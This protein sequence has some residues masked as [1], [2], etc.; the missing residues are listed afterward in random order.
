VERRILLWEYLGSDV[1]G[2]NASL[3]KGKYWVV[4]GER[5]E[6]KLVSMSLPNKAALELV[7]TLP[8]AEELLVVKPGDPVAIEV[9]VDPNV[10]LTADVQ[11]L[12]EASAQHARGD[13]KD[14]N[15]V[16]LGPA[17]ATSDL[18]RQVLAAGLTEA[19]FDVVEKSPIVVK[20]ICKQQKQQTVRINIDGRWPPRPED[21]VERTITPHATYVAFMRDGEILWKHGYVAEP[22]HNIWLE[23][24][25]TLDQALQRITQPNVLLFT[26]L[27]FNSHV[28]K[29]GQASDNG[30]FGMSQFKDGQLVDGVYRSSGNKAFEN[31]KLRD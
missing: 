1:F 24:G 28:T 11:R 12:L 29:P 2:H 31:G 14:G 7:K 15:V 17:D 9:D 16:M 26:R 10:V 8:S 20:A 4:P 19:G 6:R 21:I 27:K 3:R 5:R 25:E 18:I 13:D 30:A 22:F 23:R